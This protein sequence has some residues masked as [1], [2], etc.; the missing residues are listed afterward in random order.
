MVENKN[1]SK[2]TVRRMIKSD[3]AKINAVD[4]SLRGKSRVT[5]WPFTFDTYWRIYEPAMCYVA[6]FEGMVVGFVAGV[7]ESE[8]R[9]NYL[10]GLPR[11]MNNP[12]KDSPKVGWIEMMGVHGDHWGKGIGMALIET[13]TTEC[14]KQGAVIRIIV[15]QDD[16]NL[17]KF[18]SGRGFNQ[19]EFI[20]YEL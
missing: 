1:V 8:E 15:R 6:V 17:R 14:K 19:S 9:S 7:I 13:F 2:V 16:E 12:A 20:S 10:V 18:L 11:T 4:N 5:T 3:L